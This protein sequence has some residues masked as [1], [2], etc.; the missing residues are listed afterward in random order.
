MKPEDMN[1]PVYRKYTNGRSYFRILSETE[2]EELRPLGNKVFLSR[3]KADKW[4]ERQFIN[5]LLYHYQDMA[6]AIEEEEYQS[7]AE[8]VQDGA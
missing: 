4:P 1:F 7:L 5:D 8:R 3:I 6:C 2:F